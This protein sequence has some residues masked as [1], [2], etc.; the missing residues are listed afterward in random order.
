MTAHPVKDHKAIRLEWELREARSLQ[1]IAVFRSTSYEDGYELVAQLPGE[2]REYTDMVPRSN[3]P[4]FYFLIL[5]DFFGY[6]QPGRLSW[7]QSYAREPMSPVNTAVI[8]SARA[9][10]GGRASAMTS[11]AIISTAKPAVRHVL[12]ESRPIIGHIQRPLYLDT[13]PLTDEGDVV[14]YY[15]TAV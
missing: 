15:C 9:W 5:R 6:Q 1:G 14:S 8:L 11:L 7:L 4:Y 13:L 2:A 12:Q 10:H 3:E